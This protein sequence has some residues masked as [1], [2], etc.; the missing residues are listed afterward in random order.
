MLTQQQY[1]D[2]KNHAGT[3]VVL[4]KYTYKGWFN[5]DKYAFKLA[6]VPEGTAPG[7]FKICVLKVSHGEYVMFN[8]GDYV[9]H[10][11]LVRD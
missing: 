4:E 10:P 1:N 5:R 2:I 9:E 6:Y 7:K 11:L 3:G 8:V